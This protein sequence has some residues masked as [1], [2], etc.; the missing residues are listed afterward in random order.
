MQAEFK[1]QTDK[2][3]C[4]FCARNEI[5]FD[6]VSYL[7]SR[8]NLTM[9]SPINNTSTLSLS[10]FFFKSVVLPHGSVQIYF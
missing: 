10:F 2:K 7:L 3:N 9:S 5:T 8:N 1:M 4:F 6:F